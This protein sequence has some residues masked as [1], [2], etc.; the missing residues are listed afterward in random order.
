MQL[1]PDWI[2]GFVDGEGCFCIS[3][4]NM[5][6]MTYK[7]QVRL[8]FKVTQHKNSIQVLY[9][10]KTFFGVGIIK[11][12]SKDTDIMEFTCSKFENIQSVIIPF[13]EKHRLKTAKQFDFFRFRR[14]SII[15][16]RGEHLTKE[17]L[18][19][20][21]KLRNRMTSSGTLYQLTETEIL[22]ELE[23]IDSQS[24]T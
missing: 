13:F 17:G 5:S 19:Y 8:I 11:P 22:T 9:A 15:M 10:L 16:T 20:I 7:K 21:E 2:V 6:S 14:A 12:Q 18:I 3:V 23:G 24:N 1:T 4:Q